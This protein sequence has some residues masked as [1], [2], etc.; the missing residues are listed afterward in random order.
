MPDL[1]A[2][3]LDREQPS[4]EEQQ[5]I[6]R[7]FLARAFEPA[8]RMVFGWLVDG[9]TAGRK[10]DEL[11]ELYKKARAS[12]IGAGTDVVALVRTKVRNLRKAAVAHFERARTGEWV[13]FIPQNPPGAG[14]IATYIIVWERRKSVLELPGSSRMP[15]GMTDIMAAAY[16]KLRADFKFSALKDSTTLD[17]ALGQSREAIA[18]MLREANLF[19]KG[20]PKEFKLKHDT[21]RGVEGR[22]SLTPPKLIGKRFSREISEPDKAIEE[23]YSE[24]LGTNLV[25]NCE[26]IEVAALA[27]LLSI[28]AKYDAP[29]T[30]RCQDKSGR[31]QMF[32]LNR[33]ERCHFL[34]TADS[35]FFFFGAKAG[36]RYAQVATIHAEDQLLLRRGR[37]RKMSPRLFLYSHSSAYMQ[38]LSI[39]AGRRVPNALYGGN[40]GFPD[41]VV[42]EMYSSIKNMHLI[43]SLPDL[44]HKALHMTKEGDLLFAWMPLCDGLRQR[45]RMERAQSG[46]L[47]L[48]QVGNPMKHWISLYRHE[49]AVKLETTFFELFA[50]EWELCRTDRGFGWTRGLLE[51]YREFWDHFQGGSGLED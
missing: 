40:D 34:I 12:D 16:G 33:D 6:V 24:I 37:E 49:E 38:F 42:E 17:T 18:F 23:R 45:D 44:V 31:E 7:G 30:I 51:G 13:F 3:K 8:E 43:D 2:G 50:H 5:V 32:E 15:S 41:E 21:M 39:L 36:L 29:W 25:I 10:S 20:A 4:E 47:L 19:R 35:P 48:E 14:N 46:G 27:T 22:F 1:A 9:K 11:A 26:C 28:V